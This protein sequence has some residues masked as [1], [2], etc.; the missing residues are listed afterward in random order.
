MQ[1][2][3]ID[4]V[5]V[6][7]MVTLP[8]LSI[9]TDEAIFMSRF[10]TIGAVPTARLGLKFIVAFI[11]PDTDFCTSSIVLGSIYITT[12]DEMLMLAPEYMPWGTFIR[13]IGC[14]V[15]IRCIISTGVGEDTTATVPPPLLVI[16]IDPTVM[17]TATSRSEGASP[18]FTWRAVVLGCGFGF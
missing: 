4:A 13:T 14:I 8:E 15:P 7:V 11:G 5:I 16:D 3:F 2:G 12:A 1:H 17:L 9:E 10:R 6:G 18:R